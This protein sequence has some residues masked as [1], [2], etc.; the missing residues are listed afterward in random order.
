MRMLAPYEI[1]A[2]Q[3]VVKSIVDGETPVNAL[4][5]AN[6]HSICNLPGVSYQ[7]S[8][9]I[10]DEVGKSA[11]I[12]GCT[13]REAMETLAIMSI[14]RAFLEMSRKGFDIFK[15]AVNPWDFNYELANTMA[16]SKRMTA[17][18]SVALANGIQAH[19]DN[20]RKELERF[21]NE[22]EIP[23]IQA[24]LTAYRK[25]LLFSDSDETYL[26]QSTP[27]VEISDVVWQLF[28][29]PLEV[30]YDQY[31]SLIKG[32]IKQTASDYFGEEDISYLKAMDFFLR[33]QF[34]EQKREGL[35]GYNPTLEQA[36]QNFNKFIDR[37]L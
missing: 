6:L 23:E 12:N 13:S 28:A 1:T 16:N 25:A 35:L 31:T 4:E 27:G 34:I 33:A 7:A 11:E 29:V 21:N 32:Y 30:L 9:K 22:K 17:E 2:L 14:E 19:R 8:R 20:C 37:N 10:Q 5:I 26:T 24:V 36:F 15:P 3:T 18:E